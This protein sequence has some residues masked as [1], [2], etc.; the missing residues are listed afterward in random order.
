LTFAKS[1][2]DE[3]KN[4]SDK[5]VKRTILKNGQDKNQSKTESKQ[6]PKQESTSESESFSITPILFMAFMFVISIA[7]ALFL[8]PLYLDMGLQADFSAFGGEN[9]PYIPFFYL[10]VILVFTA[11]ILFVTRKRR[12]GFIKY[13]FLG[14]ICLSMMYVFY[15][16]FNFILF[17]PQEQEWSNQVEISG[18][19]SAVLVANLGGTSD[20][21]IIIGT[22]TGDVEVYDDNLDLLWRID[23]ELT[24]S[25]KDLA[26]ADIDKD[27]NLDL[28]VLS[29][30]IYIFE[31]TGQQFEFNITWSDPTNDYTAMILVPGYIVHFD[32]STATV[33]AILGVSD[34]VNLGDNQVIGADLDIISFYNNTFNV[35]DFI[36]ID[37]RVTT[38]AYGIFSN[39]SSPEVLLGTENGILSIPT[40]DASQIVE[41]L[42]P[43]IT[44][45]NSVEGIQIMNINNKG[46]NELIYW[47]SSGTVFIHEPSKSEPKWSQDFGDFIGGVTFGD[48]YEEVGPGYFEGK[49]MVVLADGKGHIFYSTNDKFYNERFEFTDETG[50]LDDT[51]TGIDIG[52]LDDNSDP[53]IIIGNQGG[54]YHYQY[55]HTELSDIP[56]YIGLGVS[57]LITLGLYYYP[58]WYLVDIV[59]IIVAGGVAALIGISIGLLPLLILLIILAVY[60]AISVYKTKHM[61]SLADKVMEFK[62]PILLV[63]PKKRGYSFLEQKGLKKQL[64]EGE[65]R[66]A[67]FIGL[68]DIIIPGTLVISSFNFLP[69][70]PTSIGITANLLVAIFTLVGTLVGFSVLMRFVLKGN[71]Q[72][73]LPLLN[74]G[75]ILGF[76]IS[77]F[78]IY[79]DITFGLTIPFG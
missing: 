19:T 58:E 47:D 21:E 49:E 28:I 65:E 70:D 64:D 17:P 4:E 51:A 66:E 30:S 61:V 37:E 39:S 16:I 1:K 26:V 79:Q 44:S 20:L 56:C 32:N 71:P 74:T 15:A 18:G 31:Q 11:V 46:K 35:D 54:V 10:A 25:I 59:G 14:V 3:I 76:F 75:A 38:M 60:D 2:T 43:I 69:A 8:A 13:A 63:V 52:F 42:T 62:L 40:M 29:D 55:I 41:M 73:G 72:A 53:D 23:Q 36:N 12:G 77:N 22:N 50:R 67:M 5:E 68:G 78:V 7:F 33:T 6:K 27:S 24:D 9:S 57:V 34:I 45:S 48:L